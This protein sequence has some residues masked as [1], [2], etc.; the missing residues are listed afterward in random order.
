MSEC[1]EWQ[2]SRTKGGYGVTYNPRTKRRTT[3][4]RVAYEAVHGPI[5]E[6]LEIDHLCRNRACVNVEHL[7]PV[8]PSENKIR[9]AAARPLFRCGHPRIPDNTV[10]FSGANECR[11]CR[12]R[13]NKEWRAANAEH[14][15][16]K[17]R[18][19][20]LANR[21]RLLA[22]NEARRQAKRRQLTGAGA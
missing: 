8:T 1:V 18:A 21:E 14:L 9:G 20:Y 10:R 5:P 4:S 11:E 2:G 15:K 13:R 17:R 6:G 22:E 19:Y 16:A 3:A 7:E 12:D